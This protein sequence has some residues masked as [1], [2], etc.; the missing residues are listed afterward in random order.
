MSDIFPTTPTRRRE[1][2]SPGDAARVIGFG[3][4]TLERAVKLGALPVRRTQ[5]GQLI[6][7]DDA[8]LFKRKL[9]DLARIEWPAL[10]GSQANR[11]PKVE[12]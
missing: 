2:L 8:L 1:W 9:L 6:D 7:K 4:N 10:T 11:P 12:G 3:R 5:H